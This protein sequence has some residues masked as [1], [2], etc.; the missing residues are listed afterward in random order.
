MALTRHDLTTR[1]KIPNSMVSA[2]FI[3]E[4]GVYEDIFWSVQKQI[5][6]KFVSKQNLSLKKSSIYKIKNCNSIKLYE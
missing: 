4:G 6:K 5:M 2:G 1:V 3:T